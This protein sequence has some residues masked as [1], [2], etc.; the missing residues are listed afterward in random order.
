MSAEIFFLTWVMTKACIHA[1]LIQSVV[2]LKHSWIWRSDS[3]VLVKVRRPLKISLEGFSFF[4]QI[5]RRKD[6]TCRAAANV[7]CLC[8]RKSTEHAVNDCHVWAVSS[9]GNWQRQ[10]FTPRC[11]DSPLRWIRRLQKLPLSTWAHKTGTICEVGL[12]A[13]RR[14]KW[15]SVGCRARDLMI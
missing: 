1:H 8:C 13:R 3:A 12:E 15:E 11:N 9:Q 14:G 2:G 10:R 7:L 5:H 4:C 6:S